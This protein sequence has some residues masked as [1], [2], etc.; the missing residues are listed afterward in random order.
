MREGWKT[1]PLGALLDTVIDHRGKTPKKL[2]GD[3][4]TAGI[5]VVSAI[6]IKGGQIVWAERERYVD[7]DMA[8]RWMKIPTKKNDVLLTSEAPLGEVALVPDNN[9]LVL[10]QRLFGL[11]GKSG[12]L[13]SRYL[14]WF[15]ASTK[16]RSLLEGRATGTTVV[17]IRQEQLLKVPIDY[18]P[19]EQQQRIAAVLGGLDDLIDTNQRL[20][21]QLDGFGR[22][23]FDLTCRDG[24]DAAFLG[25]ETEG[26]S[27]VSMAEATTVI[28]TGRRPKGG[29]S[30]ISEGIPSLGAESIKGL[31][32][33]DISKL[34]YV[35]TAFAAA[36]ARG[37]LESR[38]VLVYKDGGKPGDFRPHISLLG[39]GF[40]FD[41][42]VINEHVYRV[43]ANE[44]LSEPYLYFWLT[45]EPA[46]DFMRM[47]GTGAAI[48][49]LN[50][51]AFKSI[52]VGV[53]PARLHGELIPLLDAVVAAALGCAKE[54]MTLRQQRDEL[55]PL[56]MSGAV[57]PGDVTVAS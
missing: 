40:P 43:R 46:L 25:D 50:S 5:P 47:V 22:A 10:S 27:V 54:A 48:P 15:L 30:G 45:S 4:T 37:V 16:G 34:K 13:D 7:A 12:V 11:R 57:T 23:V 33:F 49:G 42:M 38:D 35:P 55:L 9:P 56:L 14:R 19:L 17:G 31:A 32:Q 51:T 52:P 20:V 53:P 36:M 2:G 8:A 44:S 26:W 41:E 21:A 3:F 18:P 24:I 29:V 1:Q 6:H 28:E 39:D